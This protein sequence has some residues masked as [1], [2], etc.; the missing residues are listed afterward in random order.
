MEVV[1]QL[2]SGQSRSYKRYNHTDVFIYCINTVLLDSIVCQNGEREKFIETAPLLLCRNL[3]VRF[4]SVV[5]TSV[6]MFLHHYTEI[7]RSAMSTGPGF[8]C[9]FPQ[10]DRRLLLF[11]GQSCLPDC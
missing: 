11:Q 10:S 6:P 5:A 8:C 9:G 3:T 7:L 4:L 1:V 2:K